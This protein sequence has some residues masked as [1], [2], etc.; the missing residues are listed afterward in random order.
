M[1]NLAEVMRPKTWD[2]VIGNSHIVTP[3]RK[4][5]EEG[6]LSKSILITGISGSGKS[7]IGK[8]IASSL[9]AEIYEIDCGADG[10][11]ERIREVVS[12]ATTHSLFAKEK[13]FVL[14]EVHT[15]SKA[16]QSALLKTLEES[17]EGVFVLLT[18]EIAKILP[19]IRSR[20]VVYETRPANNEQVGEAV[21]RVLDYYN[22]EVENRADFWGLIEQAEGSLRQTYSLMEKLIASAN[23]DRVITS[24]AFKDA[25]GTSSEEK[26]HPHLPKAFLD[27]DLKLVFDTLKEVKKEGANPYSTIVGLYN[28]LKV[29]YLNNN[30]VPPKLLEDLSLVIAT[31]QAEW[32]H[33]EWVAW[34]HLT[35]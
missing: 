12:S 29:V 10:S 20:C 1:L 4:Q 14:D 23:E 18:T 34:R 6:N 2:E 15:L 13:V 30:N 26:V 11:V 22:M 31:R 35:T 9:N 33:I 28:Y 19:T 25:L 32:E 16:A 21:T 24:Q 8:L 5:L 17:S 7:T 3:I 27:R